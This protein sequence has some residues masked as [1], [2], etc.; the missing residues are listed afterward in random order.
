MSAYPAN[1]QMSLLRAKKIFTDQTVI[2]SC[3]IK[4]NPITTPA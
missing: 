1:K 3:D 4:H 2:V